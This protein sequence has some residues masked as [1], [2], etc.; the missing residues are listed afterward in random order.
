MSLRASTLGALGTIVDG[1]VRDVSEQRELEWPIW[2][3][4]VGTSS[5]NAIAFVS[6]VGELAVCSV[7]ETDGQVRTG[8]VLVAD[9]NGV[10]CIPAELLAAVVDLVPKLVEIDELCMD[11][12]KAGRGV[13][14]TFKARRG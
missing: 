10:V 13:E 12:V 7:R 6:A 3:K 4:G 8:D 11:D 14:E 5:S 2:S 1:N 9:V